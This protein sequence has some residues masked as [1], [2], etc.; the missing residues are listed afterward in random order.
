MKGEGQ[1]DLPSPPRKTT[2]KMPSLIRVKYTPT[3]KD[4]TFISDAVVQR[5]SLL[6]SFGK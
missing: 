4:G 5:V 2:L 6:Y 1:V 3:F